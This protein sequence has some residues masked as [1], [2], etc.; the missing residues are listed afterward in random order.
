MITDEPVRGGFAD[1]GLY[2][3][4]GI[5]FARAYLRLQVPRPP[6]SHLIGMRLTQ[7]GVGSATITV[8]ASPWLQQIDGAIDT[9]IPACVALELAVITT[10]P[11]AKELHVASLSVSHFRPCTLE[12][13]PVVV[14]GRVLHTGPNFTLAEATVEDAL[15]RQVMSVTGSVLMRDRPP[16]TI[17]GSAHATEALASPSYPTPDPYLRPLPPGVA[18][19]PYARFAEEAA[20]PL[21]RRVL[22]GELPRVPLWELTGVTMADVAEG[23]GVTALRTTDWLGAHDRRVSAGVLLSLAAGSL[24]G[25]ALSLCPPGRR[26]GIIDQNLSL[27]RPVVPDGRDLL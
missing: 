9:R 24:A 21:L 27:F 12:H 7:V 15:G 19:V 16:G 6:L 14:R 4:P 3:L 25:S 1:L 17:S 22:S 18:P 13:I 5:D 11:A 23:V 20:L 2:Q 26:M 8:P 10:A